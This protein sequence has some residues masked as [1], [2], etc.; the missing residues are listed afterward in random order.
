VTVRATYPYSSY[1]YPYTVQI[2]VSPG[3]SLSEGEPSEIAAPQ[4]WA[5]CTGDVGEMYGRYTGEMY[6]RCR[7]D[8]RGSAS[9]SPR[10]MC[11]RSRCSS[12]VATSTLDFT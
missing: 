5:R 4:V 1:P 6:G 3:V 7:G 12:P 11:T 8:I 10:R 2:L 9:R